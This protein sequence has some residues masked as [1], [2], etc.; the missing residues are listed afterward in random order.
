MDAYCFDRYLRSREHIAANSACPE[1][2]GDC[3]SVFAGLAG[4]G[5]AWT[6]KWPNSKGSLWACHTTARALG[7]VPE[8]PVDRAEWEHKAGLVAAYRDMWGHAHQ[9]EPIAPA[10]PP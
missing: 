9:H 10:Q 8:H 4:L 5:T 1:L 7:S 3:V 2:S 6:R